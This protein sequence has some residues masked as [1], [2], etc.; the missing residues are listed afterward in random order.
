MRRQS[1][2]PSAVWSD[3]YYDLVLVA[4]IVVLSGS[5]A[6]DHSPEYTMWL[7]VVFGLIWSTWVLTS[8]V[9]GS[10]GA[11]H[12]DPTAVE[13]ALLTVQMGALLL[14]TLS[15]VT[16]SA[17]AENAFGLLLSL[18]LAAAV[19]LGLLARRRGVAV[20]LRT[21]GLLGFAAAM[22]GVAEVLPG[23]ALGLATV[24]WWSALIATLAGGWLGL[25]SAS[26]DPHQL[27]HRFGEL[28]I[29]VI[30][31]TLLKMA[32]SANEKGFDKLDSGGLAL[33][34]IVVT[35]MWWDYFSDAVRRPPGPGLR[36]SAWAL[37]HFILHLALIG[38]AVGLGKLVVADSGLGHG[39]T[40][41]LIGVPLTLA[42]LALALL[43]VFGDRKIAPVRAGVHAAATIFLGGLTGFAWMHP[44]DAP[45]PLVAWMV[46]IVALASGLVSALSRFGAGITDPA[47]QPTH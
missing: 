21:L 22:I 28:T 6:E 14:L 5:W 3:L 39:G 23:S 20:S 18:A 31:E 42:M 44:D 32:L 15:S 37:S 36:R 13:I 47:P 29:I 17:G 11:R 35:A 41:L 25:R 10:F 26:L 2:A 16:D 30:G 7:G 46:V 4:G 38:A 24:A 27:S 8:L 33:A 45:L 12:S 1:A 9:M 40:A 34:M 19:A 43:D